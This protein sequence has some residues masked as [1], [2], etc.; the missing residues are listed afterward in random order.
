MQKKFWVLFPLS[1]TFNDKRGNP[2]NEDNRNAFNVHCEYNEIIPYLSQNEFFR[3]NIHRQKPS[4]GWLVKQ[5]ITI[6]IR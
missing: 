2:R 4:L 1:L 6:I 3:S 5:R